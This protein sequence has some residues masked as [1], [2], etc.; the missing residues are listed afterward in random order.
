M[1]DFME[2]GY[3]PSKPAKVK[4][5]PNS[6]TESRKV[7]Q[8]MK[9]PDLEYF[10]LTDESPRTAFMKYMDEKG[11][12]YDKAEL[13]KIIDET[14][15][16]LMSL[17]HYYNRPRPH[18]VNEKIKPVDS[19]SDNTPA[20]PSGHAYQSYMLARHLIKKHPLHYFSFYSIANR[21]ANAR[22]SVGLHY[23]SDNK[24][25]FDLAHSM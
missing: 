20:Y 1:R 12:E 3:E 23:P 15:P 2:R 7:L 24:K 16:V 4:Y 13:K 11:L 5:Y 18:Q 21:I 9:N 6:L 19:V 8:S 10:K 25:A 14:E 22:V 17:K